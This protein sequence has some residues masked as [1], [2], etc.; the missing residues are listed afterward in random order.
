MQQQSRVLV[1]RNPLV[2]FLLSS[3][4]LSFE[5]RGGRNTLPPS[6]PRYENRRVRARFNANDRSGDY[7]PL[8]FDIRDKSNYPSRDDSNAARQCIK[9][10]C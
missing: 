7:F 4:A 9:C 8:I 3:M 1:D 10:N 2:L 5:T 6:C